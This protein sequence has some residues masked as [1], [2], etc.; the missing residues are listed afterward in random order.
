MLI[1]NADHVKARGNTI[2]GKTADDNPG[3]S[4]SFQFRSKSTFLEKQT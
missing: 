3:P 1:F 2:Q 4:D